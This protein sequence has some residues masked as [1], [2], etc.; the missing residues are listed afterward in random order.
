M[1]Q[2]I[3]KTC[4]WQ[5]NLFFHETY[6]SSIQPAML[7]FPIA[8]IIFQTKMGK[9]GKSGKKGNSK[10]AEKK[11]ERLEM[12]KLMNDRVKLV[13]A[14]NDVEDPLENLPSFKVCNLFEMVIRFV[15]SFQVCILIYITCVC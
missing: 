4:E 8:I 3:L 12:E 1:A 6:K 9:A 11:K 13:K 14:A 5:K 7:L 10:A 15:S 2:A